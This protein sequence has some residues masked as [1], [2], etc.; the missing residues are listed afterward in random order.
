MSFPRLTFP[1]TVDFGEAEY[2]IGDQ[3]PFKYGAAVTEFFCGNDLAENI[4]DGLLLMRRLEDILIVFGGHLQSHI[5]EWPVSQKDFFHPERSAECTV[6]LTFHPVDGELGGMVERWTFSCLWDFLYIEL[7]KAI[8][9]GN[10]PRECRL[11]GH[12]FLHEQGDR[13][14]YCERIAPSE[15]SKTCREVGARTVFEKKIQDE[16]AWKLYKRAY[17]KYYARYMKG[18][19][20]QDAFKAWAVQA[21][22][23]RD[24]AIEQIRPG[25]DATLKAQIIEWLKE[26]LNRQ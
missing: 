16:E 17:K 8:Q 12:W 18:N 15:E 21:A 7:A 22:T 4:G 3:G 26:K 23:D 20:S 14:M 19:M 24:V 5:R 10:A 1:L 6:G 11:C 2:W 25:M 13:T 9:R